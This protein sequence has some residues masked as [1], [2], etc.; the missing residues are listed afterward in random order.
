MQIYLVFKI[1]KEHPNPPPIILYATQGDLVSR[2][3]KMVETAF[4]VSDKA[5][6]GPIEAHTKIMTAKSPLLL[7]QIDIEKENYTRVRAD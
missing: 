1:W 5:P 3:G 6:M 7:F 2:F 4:E